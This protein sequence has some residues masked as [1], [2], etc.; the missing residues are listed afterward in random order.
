MFCG[1]CG[2]ENETGA[3]FCKGCGQALSEAGGSQGPN[4]GVTSQGAISSQPTI[5]NAPKVEENQ[6]VDKAKGIPKRVWIGVSAAVVAFFILLCVAIAVIINVSSTINLNKYLIIE[7]NGYEGYGTA[8]VSID[9]DAIEAKYG[10]KVKF[11][12]QAKA[13]LGGFLTLMTPMDALQDGV[14]VGLD[15]YKGLS[16]GDSIQY[17]WNIKE[18]LT[19]YV[20][21]K[22]K[23]KDASYTV[24]G[25]EEIAKFD[26]FAGVEV[27]FSG[28]A[29]IGEAVISTYPSD[30]GI[31]Y[32]FDK[33]YGLMN[34]DTVT[35][36]VSYGW[37]TEA[38]YAED[39]G[40]L[41]T[42]TSKEYTVSGLDEYVMSY[43]GLTEE[44]L[45]KVKSEA[46]D[47]IYSYAASSYSS[48]YSLT[49]LTY[50][51]YILNTVKDSSGY[52]Y[53]YND[54]Y[55]IYS[56]T[57][58]S[59]NE[60]FLI[61][62]AYF[63]VRF[64]NILSNENGI[65]YGDNFGIAGYSQFPNSWTNTQGYFNP[66]MCYMELVEANKELYDSECGD[67]FEQYAVTGTIQKI[68][69]IDASYKEELSANAKSRI[70]SYI[71]AN[72][73]GGSVASDLTEVG[74]CLL[75]AKTQGI[76]YAYNNKYYVVYSATV[77]ND[78]GRFDETTVYFPVEYDGIVKLTGEGYL[79][80]V[81]EGIA[82]YSSFPGS[83]YSTN[84]YVDGSEMFSKIITA[85]RDNYTYE[86]SDGMKVFG[87]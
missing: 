53:T 82:G 55:I 83:W 22:I 77:S 61:E 47:T 57:I 17:S 75:V 44:F 60:S 30:N 12:R 42:V 23:F 40:K 16:N 54:L 29:P 11:T 13:E 19:K 21:C 5:N 14:S 59:T 25:L 37:R 27:E 84:G 49:D 33:N 38:D 79:Y 39:Y 68:D 9:W 3:K 65:S 85:N 41:P 51:G 76:D 78:A 67:G 45:S 71:E 31:S 52:V 72:Y 36:T 1:N 24:S 15:S 43:E 69:D 50:S 81:A 26:P 18:D 10:K 70:E 8:S 87:E 62:K 66:L 46:E 4:H 63:P 74:D 34:G 28:I 6:F 2:S 35:I 73:N 58:S 48:D 7:S 20:K 80:T 32:D 64:Y 56:G 86:V